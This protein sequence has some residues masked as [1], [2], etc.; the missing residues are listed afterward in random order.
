MAGKKRKSGKRGKSNPKGGGTGKALIPA[1]RENGVSWDT[2]IHMIPFRRGVC[3][4]G[5][6]R[7]LNPMPDVWRGT[8]TAQFS[9]KIAVGAAAA[10]RF[11]VCGN[12]PFLPWNT[13][14]GFPGPIDRANNVNTTAAYPL[15]CS[16]D[17]PYLAYRVYGS[18]AKLSVAAEAAVDA[19][20]VT[21]VPYQTTPQANYTEATQSRWAR[22]GQAGFGDGVVT[23]EN[24]LATTEMT[25]D[26]KH[27]I[28]YQSGN[29]ATYNTYPA[30]L[31]YWSMFYSLASAA[32][33]TGQIPVKV[34]VVYDVA[35][36]NPQ[37]DDSDLD[38][39]SESDKTALKRHVRK[40]E[41][42]KQAEAEQEARLDAIVSSEDAEESKA[43]S[44]DSLAY[45]SSNASSLSSSAVRL[46]M[47]GSTGV[48]S[49]LGKPVL[50]RA[51]SGRK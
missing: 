20:E 44:A 9:G 33:T 19:F 1:S 14:T 22:S 23:L 48:T 7:A 16:A 32:V 49:G 47:E 13:A 5:L 24:S 8:F 39:V 4:T 21:L 37:F 27:A 12:S 42:K 6:R 2:A 38:Q 51:P 31:W 15:L 28:F 41:L 26:A 45:S 25:G 40:V 11:D 3:F 34:T 17:G 46:G 29:A 36:E 43:S 35:L 30:S 18:A 10:G 50:K